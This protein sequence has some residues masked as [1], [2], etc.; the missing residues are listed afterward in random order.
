M[1][2]DVAF[3]LKAHKPVTDQ[4][5]LEEIQTCTSQKQSLSS[6]IESTGNNNI[7]YNIHYIVIFCE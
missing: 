6:I 4:G 5:G 3:I 7:I 2:L 1:L